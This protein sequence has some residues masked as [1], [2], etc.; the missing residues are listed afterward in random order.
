MSDPQHSWPEYLIAHD[1]AFHA[2]GVVALAFNELEYQLLRLT[3]L[4]LEF[5]HVTAVIFNKLRDTGIR[6]TLLKEAIKERQ[7]R[8]KYLIRSIISVMVV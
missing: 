5:N 1:D 7:K 2:L 8:Q 6:V 4:Y 3:L